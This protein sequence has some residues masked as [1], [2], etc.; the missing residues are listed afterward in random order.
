MSD[1][2]DTTFPSASDPRPSTLRLVRALG[3][4]LRT[5]LAPRRR[6][7]LAATL[8][9]AA[10]SSSTVPGADVVALVPRR[11]AAWTRRVGAAAAAL[12]VVVGAVG[13]ATRGGDDLPMLD[14]VAGGPELAGA[15]GAPGPSAAPDMAPMPGEGPLRG[16]S[17]AAGDMVGGPAIGWWY[18][19]VYRFE[20]AAGLPATAT[21]GPVWRLAAP[22]DLG[23]AA[24][25]LAAA[26]GLP[27]PAR[28]AA[29]AGSFESQGEDGSSLWVSA[30]GDWY[31]GG[32]W[33]AARGGWVCGSE[34]SVPGE[35]RE[36]GEGREPAEPPTPGGE[37][38]PDLGGG[39]SDGA[40]GGSPGTPGVA[41][42]YDDGCTELEPPVGVPSAERARELA[43]ALFS[44]TGQGDVLITDAYADTW[45]AWVA[46]TLSVAGLASDSGIF[47]G[48]GFGGGEVVTY[49]SGTLA[50]P[51]LVGEYPLADVATAVRRLEGELNAWSS[52]GVRDGSQ[53]GPAVMPAPM[54]APMPERGGDASGTVSSDGDAPVSSDDVVTILPAPG[55][56]R[57]LP[58]VDLPPVD[59]PGGA[60]EPVERDVLIV[61]AR[62]TTLM[63]WTASGAQL[64]VPHY[65]LLDADG[66]EWYVVAVDSRYLA[67]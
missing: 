60:G 62:V 53:E 37:P 35:V 67:G 18:P 10:S 58:D 5:P 13:L 50:R 6:E 46:G 40:S 47:V 22:D 45:G 27:A 23:A 24:A 57:P 55:G 31:Y 14:L 19:V 32:P 11:S 42:G 15:G 1:H 29:D 34:P 28:S 48:I 26:L 41:P 20:L 9:E 17:D 52:P 12:V 56:D 33:D 49:A 59:A 30:Q 39:A 4:R 7:Q 36:P 64:L 38:A 63:T 8:A 66:G 25:R 51:V 44:R 61:G 3:A 16:E 43:G 21:S 65:V 54:P 2:T